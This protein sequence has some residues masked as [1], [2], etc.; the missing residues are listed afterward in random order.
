MQAYGPRAPFVI[1]WL[2]ALARRLDRRI[3]VRLVK[4]AYWDAETVHAR[5]ARTRPP[6][7]A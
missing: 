4:G 6:V 5:G 7:T 3:M 1:D 2:D